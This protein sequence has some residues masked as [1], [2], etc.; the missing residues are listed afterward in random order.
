MTQEQSKRVIQSIG[1]CDKIISRE[2]AY[3]EQFRNVSL[4]AETEAHK[5]KLV[6]M[7]VAS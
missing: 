4:I 5:Q 7:L 2:M 6:E 3:M 1:E